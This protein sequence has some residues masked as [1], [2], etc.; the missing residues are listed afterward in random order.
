[1]KYKNF[2]YWEDIY[3]NILIS[4]DNILILD[5]DNTLIKPTSNFGSDQFFN[6]QVKQ[7]TEN[8]SKKI[9]N[10]IPKL[11]SI[12]IQICNYIDYQLCEKGIDLLLSKLKKKYNLDIILLTARHKDSY[13]SLK[14]NLINLNIF[15][16]LSNN[17][18]NNYEYCGSCYRDGII[19]CNGGNK[20]EILKNCL[21]KKK[22]CFQKIIFIDDKQYN[23]ESVYNKI[24]YIECI[25]YDGC[26]A[27]VEKFDNDCKTQV[28]EEYKYFLLNYEDIK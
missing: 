16:L 3:N 12:M 19:F 9:T 21:E 25:R 5:I 22:K 28:L 17:L 2:L 24:Q 14:K 27:E 20:G 18:I 7:I 15:N 23:L 6:W 13:K 8:G 1:M 26:L 4:K 11:L 10:S